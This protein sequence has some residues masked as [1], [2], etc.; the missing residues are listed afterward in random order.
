MYSIFDF[1]NATGTSVIKEWAVS[2]KLQKRDIGQLNQKIDML[3]LNGFGLH[4][5]LLSGPIQKQR[6]VYKLRIH[7]QRMLRPMLCKGPFSMDGEFTMLIGAIE[8]N[9]RLIPDPSLATVN[10]EVLIQSPNR[11]VLN[12]GY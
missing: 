2:E 11:R 7:G 6:H 5:N 12:E 3:R 8:M 4:P 9:F 1:T 10:R